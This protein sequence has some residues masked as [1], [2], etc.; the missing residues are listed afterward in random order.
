MKRPTTNNLLLFDLAWKSGMLALGA[1]QVIALR[2]AKIAT[3]G[4]QAGREASLMVAEKVAAL[5]AS[6]GLMLK[7][8]TRGDVG[9]GAQ[10]VLRLYQRRVSANA[11][12]L[13]RG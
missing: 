13:S 11:R 6:Q 5:S 9:K 3:G 7:A 4:P 1:Q 8:A 10:N 12:R 2:L